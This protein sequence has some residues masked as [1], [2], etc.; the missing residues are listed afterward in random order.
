MTGLAAV[1][2]SAAAA[3][4]TAY[5]GYF[6]Y[7]ER[8]EEA[9]AIIALSIITSTLLFWVHLLY[10]QRGFMVSAFATTAISASFAGAL[11]MSIVIY[12]LFFHPLRHFPGPAGPNE[13]VIFDPAAVP[14][15]LGPGSRCV[16]GPW[17]DSM[18]PLMSL[19]TTR[20]RQVHAK[21]RRIWD[22]GF[23]MK[24]LRTYEE[25][26]LQTS[27][28]LVSVMSTHAGSVVRLLWYSFDTMGVIAFGKSFGTVETGQGHFILEILAGSVK[29]F[30]ALAPVPWVIGTLSWLPGSP[31]ENFTEWCTGLTDERMK[32]DKDDEVADVM[33]NL[34]KD[35]NKSEDK[36]NALHYLNGD[37]RL[38][39]L[40]G[41]ET[42]AGT[43]THLFY[44]LVAYP[45]K[46]TLLRAELSS[47]PKSSAEV[48][49]KAL[50]DV[51]LL[52]GIINE[53]L[54]LWPAILSGLQYLTPPEGITI[55]KTFIPG[56]VTPELIINKVGY[57]PFS[58]GQQSCVGKQLAL[59]ELR[60]IV[61]MLVAKFS[62]NFAPGHDGSEVTEDLTD[63]FA[64]TPGKLKLVFTLPHLVS[65]SPNNVAGL[66]SRE[67]VVSALTS[68]NFSPFQ[69][70]RVLKFTPLFVLF[71]AVTG[72]KK[73]K[74]QV[75]PKATGNMA[76]EIAQLKQLQADMNAAFDDLFNFSQ[77]S[78]NNAGAI[79]AAKERI[80][81]M[82]QKTLGTV[83]GPA[84]SII[85]LS[86]QTN[87]DPM[88]L[89]R[90]MRAIS[91]M[92][93]LKQTDATQWEPTPLTRAL[94]VP[95]LRN[96]LIAHFDQ[97]MIIWG[98]F[99]EWLKKRG[100]KT[101]GAAD[102]NVFTEV[103]GEPVWE[104]YEN[105]PEAN[106]IYGSA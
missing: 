15:I 16:K 63:H 89:Q 47:L 18:K 67:E 92:G 88:I 55:G 69:P 83:L 58:L 25:R 61:S 60:T 21:R 22:K 36:V 2:C 31:S 3:G 75:T 99:P 91:S 20:D 26:I 85:N 66:G 86:S 6:I 48:D 70:I 104:W 19:Q 7:G 51:P 43:L 41:T 95:A 23:G 57:A 105:N 27:K 9:L 93:Y 79:A 42:T 56:N 49:F 59:L 33:S 82:A 45:S 74:I 17:Y 13:I 77:D 52:N 50:Q 80:G 10:L 84:F 30:A 8:H 34:I 97:R 81:T 65:P 38:I 29:L 1:C 4:L 53:T 54:R 46:Q 78:P 76:E 90:I 64:F 73:V 40:A 100:Y 98:R 87:A 101:T 5:L 32:A 106:A 102:D 11:W 14:I 103:L 72:S 71:C 12:R 24:A 35:Y 37:S 28:S 39:V 94:N 96:W 62:I 44:F 68:A